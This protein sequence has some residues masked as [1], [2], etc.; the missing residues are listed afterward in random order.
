M[1]GLLLL[2]RVAIADAQEFRLAMTPPEAKSTYRFPLELATGGAWEQWSKG[3]LGTASAAFLPGIGYDQWDFNAV[4][5]VPYQNPGS[6]LAL[7]GRISLRVFDMFHGLL[8]IRVGTEATYL[9][10][11][12]GSQLA[13]GASIGA[14]TLGS[15]G[16]WGGWDTAYARGFANFVIQIDA[17]KLGD[18]VGALLELTPPEDRRDVGL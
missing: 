11:D 12:R 3:P 18:P 16:I 4:V 14:G 1:V 13:A 7:G 6:D 9:T 15:F 5:R 2:P 10:F 8:P 17:S